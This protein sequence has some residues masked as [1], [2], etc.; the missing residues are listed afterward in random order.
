M[1][2]MLSVVTT[3]VQVEAEALR[4]MLQTAVNLSFNRISIDGDTS[5]NDTVL[6]LANGASGVALANEAD[7]QQFQTALNELCTILAK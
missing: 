3:D 5:T 6:L 7:V 2:T 4:G 1:A